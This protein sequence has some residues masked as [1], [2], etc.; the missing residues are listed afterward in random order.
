MIGPEDIIVPDWPAPRGV[1]A[2][3][4]TRRGG[5][6]EGKFAN[7]NL[8][9]QVGDDCVAVAENRRHLDALLPVKPIWLNQ[10]HGIAV[11]VFSG[12]A[13]DSAPVAD[14]AMTSQRKSSLRSAG[15]GLSAAAFLRY[16][17]YLCRG[18][19]C[20]MAR[21]FGGRDRIHS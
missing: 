10:V 19:A 21:P 20:G 1:K 12:D 14:A 8:G 18:D 4:T 9:A 2:F 5:V 15:S 7:L 3:F 6:S 11:H 16:R 13:A 17:E